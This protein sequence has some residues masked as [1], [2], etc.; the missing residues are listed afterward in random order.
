MSTLESQDYRNN[1]LITGALAITSGRNLGLTDDETLGVL[2]S[3]S[4]RQQAQADEAARLAGDPND[5]INLANKYA[6][7]RAD[8][9]V[10]SPT[11]R[12]YISLRFVACSGKL[13]EQ[14]FRSLFY[15]KYRKF[16]YLR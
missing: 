2:S 1:Q 13:P 12:E 11:L 7:N 5:I 6:N 4:S 3:T 15:K 16:N 10:G 9:V 8:F 14:T